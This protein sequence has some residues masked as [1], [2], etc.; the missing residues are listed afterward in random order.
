M[1]FRLILRDSNGHVCTGMLWRYKK[2]R[3]IDR[4][5]GVPRTAVL[6][7]T[8]GNKHLWL[9]GEQIPTKYQVTGWFSHAVLGINIS[10]LAFGTDQPY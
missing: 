3:F 6:A 1:R 10:T 7:Q 5:N 9:R 4:D 2:R 8:V